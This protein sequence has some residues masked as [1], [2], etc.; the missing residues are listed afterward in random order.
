MYN[1]FIPQEKDRT[2]TKI[3]GKHVI[4]NLSL[5]FLVTACDTQD[6]LA[7]ENVSTQGTLAREHV[8][9]QNTLAR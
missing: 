4:E 6:T 7:R 9:T 2:I 8:S 3:Y 1:S 5:L